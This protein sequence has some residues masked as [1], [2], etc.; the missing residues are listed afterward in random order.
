MNLR[1]HG[2]LFLRSSIKP[3]LLEDLRGTLF[4]GDIAG[5]RCLLDRP[6][7]REA[8][9]LIRNQLIDSGH[10]APESVAIQAIAFN[11][12]V[13]TNW[14]VAWH[15][16]VIFPFAKRVSSEGFDVACVKQGVDYA[17]P[18]ARVLEELLAVRL[19]LD[20]CDETNGPLRISPG[21]HCLGIVGTDDISGL[22]AEHGEE[23]CMAGEGQLLLMRPL[24]LHASSQAM[25]PKN[26]RVLHLVYHS[27]AL[28]PE[29]WHRAVGG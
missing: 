18:P 19:H 11:K 29:V 25:V 26:R 8:A 27:G 3:E 7:V 13:G 10:L 9:V 2:I 4:S 28:M 23:V 24:V 22:V 5:E 1:D 20:D 16:D 14:K 6:S 12:T 17:R 15:Q 21:T